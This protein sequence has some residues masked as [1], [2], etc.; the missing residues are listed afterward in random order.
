MTAMPAVERMTAEERPA[1]PH[2][3]RELTRG[4]AGE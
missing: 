4:F 3:R 2:G 1:R